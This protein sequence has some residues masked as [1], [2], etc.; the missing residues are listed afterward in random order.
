MPLIIKNRYDRLAFQFGTR[1]ALRST[2]ELV[3][4]LQAQLKAER[5]QHAFDMSE[6]QKQISF[7]LRDNAELRLEIARRD[8]EAAFANLPFPS[9]MMH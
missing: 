1:S 7:L 6:M 9:G 8:R 5:N 3:D 4:Q 2:S